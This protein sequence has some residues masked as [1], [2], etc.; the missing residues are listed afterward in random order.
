MT[1]LAF[2]FGVLPLAISQGAGAASRHSVGTGVVGGMIAATFLALLFVPLFVWTSGRFW[3][4]H[5]QSVPAQL[6]RHGADLDSRY[7]WSFSLRTAL[8]HVGCKSQR[9]RG[10]GGRVESSCAVCGRLD[11]P[12]LRRGQSRPCTHSE[13]TAGRAPRACE[14]SGIKHLIKQK[15]SIARVP[16]SWPTRCGIPGKVDVSRSSS[17]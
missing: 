2:V 10:G 15:R 8:I 12:D 17:S 5:E 1:S 13:P 14:P 6:E 4:A 16:R 11:H 9:R 3:N 7:T